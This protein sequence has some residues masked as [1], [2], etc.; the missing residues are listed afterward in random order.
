VF[1]REQ[2][3]HLEALGYALYQPVARAESNPAPGSVAASDFWQTVLGRNIARFCQN[4]DVTQL[5]LPTE[6]QSAQ[7][8]R[9]LWLQLKALRQNQ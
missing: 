8:K 3:V 6:V 2:R 7:A 9:G 5:H 4:A 1:S